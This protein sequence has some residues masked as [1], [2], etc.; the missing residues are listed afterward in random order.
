MCCLKI[1]TH[2]ENV[3]LGNFKV[4]QKSKNELTETVMTSL[5]GI[6]LQ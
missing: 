5:G 4:V 6:I 1:G 2:S 3:S